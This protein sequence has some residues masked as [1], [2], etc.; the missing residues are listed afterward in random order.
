M[1]QQ[2]FVSKMHRFMMNCPYICNYS[3]LWSY[4]WGQISSPSKY[5]NFIYCSRSVCYNLNEYGIDGIIIGVYLTF[6]WPAMLAVQVRWRMN[7][8]IQE[9]YTVWLLLHEHCKL[10]WSCVPRYFEPGFTSVF[11]RCLVNLSATTDFCYPPGCQQSDCSMLKVAH[12]PQPAKNT[13]WFF[14]QAR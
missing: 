13:L 4:I 5:A 7:Q 1:Y 3:A 9:K 12:R 2:F 11:W 8:S 10:G 14:H 6:I